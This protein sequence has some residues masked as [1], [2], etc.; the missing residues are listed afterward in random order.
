MV[1]SIPIIITEDLQ[2]QSYTA[3][4]IFFPVRKNSIFFCGDLDGSV[5]PHVLMSIFPSRFI[6]LLQTQT[7]FNIFRAL[8]WNNPAV[9][10][11]T[12]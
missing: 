2:V 3:A 11:S 1:E 10:W 12:I 7:V 4:S 5:R 6:D 9:K 8:L